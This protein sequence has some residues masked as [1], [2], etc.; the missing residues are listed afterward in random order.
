VFAAWKGNKFLAEKHGWVLTTQA[1]EEFVENQNVAR[2]IAH[3]WTNFLQEDAQPDPPPYRD[4][5]G[6]EDSKKK[7]P[8]AAGVLSGAKRIAA[9]VKVLLDLLGPTAKPVSQDLA[10]KRAAV[11]AEC[12]KNDGGDWRSYFTEPVARKV[13][14]QLEIKHDMKLVT[15]HDAK[16]SVCSACDC[17]LP[18]KVWVGLDYILASTSQ[19]TMARFVPNCWVLTEQ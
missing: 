16:L 2:M 7:D 8:S 18:L 13:K 4:L 11:C 19:D 1:A 6:D 17:P 5:Y 10:V 9:G 15:I 14:Q 12:V 3:G